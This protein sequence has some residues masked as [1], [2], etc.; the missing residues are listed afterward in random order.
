MKKICFYNLVISFTT[1]KKIILS[2]F[3]II[4]SLSYGQNVYNVLGAKV[5]SGDAIAGT[6]S[7]NVASLQNGVYVVKSGNASHKFIKK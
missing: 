3:L 1:M 6:T 2:A 5:L 7:I 4:S